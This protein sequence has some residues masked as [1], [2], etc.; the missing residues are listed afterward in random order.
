[1]NL[2]KNVEKRITSGYLLLILTITS[3]S[4]L[5]ILT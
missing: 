1:M 4:H 2:L 3:C 5:F